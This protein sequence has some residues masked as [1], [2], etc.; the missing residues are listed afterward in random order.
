MT[1]RPKALFGILLA[2]LLVRLALWLWFEGVE[3]R[4]YDER[5]YDSI[6]VSLAERGEFALRGGATSA[7]PPLYPAL[8]SVVYRVAGV[9]DYQ[10]VRLLQILL[11]LALVPVVFALGRRL[12]DERTGW[13][14][15]GLTAFYPSLWGHDYLLLT[16]VLFTLL[17]CG[18]ALALVEFSTAKEPR[19]RTL[20]AAGIL[21]GLAALTRS[22]LFLYPPLL[23]VAV[24]AL[25]RE[26][27][28]RRMAAVV[29]F[30][31]A[32][33]IVVAPWIARNSR[34][35]GRLSAI[36]S[37]STAT[38]ARHSPLRV[39][40]AE[41]RPRSIEPP[42]PSETVSGGGAGRGDE[43]GPRS[44]GAGAARQAR[45]DSWPGPARWTAMIVHN[46]LAFWQIDR[47]ITGAASRGW[48]G[49]IPRPAVLALA[50]VLAG[51]Y[52]VL[53]LG[54]L[55]GLVLRPPGNRLAFGLVVSIVVALW[56]VHALTFGHSRYHLPLMPLV[57]VFAAQ[58]LVTRREPLPRRRLVAAAVAASILVVSW[59]GNFVREDAPDLE[60]RLWSRAASDRAGS[61]TERARPTGGGGGR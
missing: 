38:A 7:R 60:R 40:S 4:I 49:P 46:G 11:N 57:A 61:S 19:R 30:V 3:P 32:F 54:G 28:R 1:A 17:L 25:W 24:F 5:D 36:D 23:A 39:P 12:Y 48:L 31:A 13:I 22:S 8:V 56:G 45:W 41:Q 2:A 14:A 37:Y 26:S 33:G 53:L 21:L 58:L 15:A 59:I 35:H 27:P 29:L 43:A 9:R 20:V 51:Y 34:L 18:G 55:F 6:A 44:R 47:E 52:V 50:A 16:E 10:A 42:A